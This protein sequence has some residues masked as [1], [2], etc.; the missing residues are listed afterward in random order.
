[1]P[2]HAVDVAVAGLFP[3]K[4]VLVV[5]GG[6]PRTVSVGSRTPEGVRL[7]SVEGETAVVEVGGRQQV[8]RLGERAVS[9][10]GI[11]GA[12]VVT[13]HANG[14][15]HFITPGSINGAGVVFIVDT[16]ASMVSMGAA[17]A[18]RAGIDYL[19]GMPVPTLTATGPSTVWRVKL[20][21]VRVGDV[22]L[23]NVDGAVHAANLPVVL[24]G[25][26]FLNRMEMSR[27]GEQLTLRQR[28]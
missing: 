28:Y 23:R 3:G 12:S 8:L 25:M 18:A 24:L 13:L 6:V 20:D 9:A 19:K 15:G 11:S 27:S 22:T 10:P 2:A 4:A 5:D 16:G 7:V 14:Q 21:S 17:D 26:S 1:L